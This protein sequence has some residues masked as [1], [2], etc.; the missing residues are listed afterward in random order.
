M[1]VFNASAYLRETLD[2]LPAQ[3]SQD[4][5]LIAVDDG[6]TDDSLEILNEYAAMHANCIVRG[7]PNSGSAAL[8]RNVAL[9]IAS[10]E[11]VFFL[12]SDDL[13]APQTVENLLKAADESGSDVVLCKME[14]FG[15]GTRSLPRSVFKTE[16]RAEDFIDSFAYRTLSP[17]KMFRRSMIE[18]HR[19]RFPLGYSN[20]EDQPFVMRAYL[21]SNHISAISDQIYYWIRNRANG[22][23]GT[24]AAGNVSKAG[25]PPGKDLTKNLTVI[26]VV[27]RHTDSGARRDM[28]LERFFTGAAGLTFAFNRR[29][30]ALDRSEQQQLIDR[31]RKV[32][33]LWNDRLRGNANSHVREL[34]DTLFSGSLE[35]VVAMIARPNGEELVLKLKERIDR[36]PQLPLTFTKSRM[37]KPT[38]LVLEH[39]VVNHRIAFDVNWGRDG[40]R[41][42]VVGRDAASKR[43]LR[44]LLVGRASLLQENGERHSLASWDSGTDTSVLLSDILTQMLWIIHFAL[45]IPHEGKTPAV[46][47]EGLPKA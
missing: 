4:F 33:H 35:E 7:I 38:C 44:N 14:N 30:L 2:V 21:E 32:S 45:S 9:D 19:I 36:S 1:P 10:G 17:M 28:L 43:F 29:F 41:L 12:D 20:G 40:W 42:S 18:R 15:I 39:V 3:T 11:F 8:P 47:Q 25:Q 5:E 34:L 16:R 31:A 22:V 24:P 6:S 13:I 46:I 27:E 23:P 37:Y 26:D